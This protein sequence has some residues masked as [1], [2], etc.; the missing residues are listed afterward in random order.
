M[1]ENN[2]SERNIAFKIKGRLFT[3][4]NPL[5]FLSFSFVLSLKS[6][7]SPE[8]KIEVLFSFNPIKVGGDFRSRYLTTVDSPFFENQELVEI[9]T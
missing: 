5:F 6:F 9:I 7:Y 8:K 3:I 2:S 1:G 4:R